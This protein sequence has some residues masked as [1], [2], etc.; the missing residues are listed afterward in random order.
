ML[1]EHSTQLISGLLALRIIQTFQEVLDPGLPARL[2]TDLCTLRFGRIGSLQSGGSSV[3][4]L[5]H[6]LLAV[7]ITSA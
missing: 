5:Q 4:A 2:L 7:A 6:G 3:Q 1:G